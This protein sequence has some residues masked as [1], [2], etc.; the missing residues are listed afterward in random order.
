MR[1]PKAR[2]KT[3][4]AMPHIHVLL[5]LSFLSLGIAGCGTTKPKVSLPFQEIEV[6]SFARESLDQQP[7]SDFF[8]IASTDEIVPPGSGLSF[9]QS[10]LDRIE[11]VDFDQSFVAV[12]LVGQIP[13]NG[14]VDEV[15]RSRDTVTIW[16][17]SYSIGPGNYAL[18]EYTAAY[19][20]VSVTKQGTW[21]RDVQFLL[22]VKAA[23]KDWVRQTSHHIP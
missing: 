1:S 7:E 23:E 12:F 17:K 2:Q 16:L 15:V 18:E 20:Y 11:Q 3:V 6:S 14:A 5:V 19:R 9:L 13:G 21:N 10:T 4:H 8:I 22:R